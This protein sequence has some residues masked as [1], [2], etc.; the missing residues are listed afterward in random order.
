MY[1]QSRSRAIKLGRLEDGGCKMIFKATVFD[2]RTTPPTIVRSDY[3]FGQLE[4]A[5]AVLPETYIETNGSIMRTVDGT[6]LMEG[7]K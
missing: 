5:G 3:G 6:V 7:P 1:D 2:D 4:Q